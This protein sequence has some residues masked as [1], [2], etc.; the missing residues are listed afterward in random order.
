MKKEYKL[1]SSITGGINETF[2]TR[3]E[4][5]ERF[6][7]IKENKEEFKNNSMIYAYVNIYNEN[8]KIKDS[9]T[10]GIIDFNK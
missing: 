4:L 7:Y 6:D 10:L 3:D 1:L 2:K 9:K 8:D 5:K